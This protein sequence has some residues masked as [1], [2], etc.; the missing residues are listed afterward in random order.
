MKTKRK[1]K[2]FKV[3]R[4]SAGQ[5]PKYES[6]KQ[7][8]NAVLDY[9]NS[10]GTFETPSK[11]GLLL[12]L[13]ISRETYSQY[14][15]KF[16]DT[17]RRANMAIEAAWNQRLLGQQATGPIFYLKNAFKE[18]YKDKQ[19]IGMTVKSPKPILGGISKK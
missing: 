11:A 13:D 18:T 7:L 3:R 16:P 17:V 10:L 9:F 1:N 4:P 8:L 5:P 19:D 15:K 6:D 2:G 14:K 12:H